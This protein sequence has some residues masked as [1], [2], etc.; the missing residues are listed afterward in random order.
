[1]IVIE[2]I[3]GQF[4]NKLLYYNN[5]VQVSNRYSVDYFIHEFVGDDIFKFSVDRSGIVPHHTT[6]ITSSDLLNSRVSISTC[7][8]TLLKP[9]LGELFF[10]FCDVDTHKI[11]EFKDVLVPTPSTGTSVGIHFRGK[12]FKSWNPLSI[13]PTKYYVDSMSYVLDTYND[14][15]FTLYTDDMS[16]VSY[17]EVIGYLESNNLTFMTGNINSLSEDFINLSYCDIIISSPSTFAICAGFC[18]K[19][20]KKIIHS[21]S[22]VDYRVLSNGRF[23][24]GFDCGGNSNYGKYKLI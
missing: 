1:M 23:W 13:L 8:I 21:K 9:C 5:L 22:W 19:R 6:T 20:N 7:D 2:D 12:D 15:V 4:G 14:I 17:I 24:V 10:D 11:F 18:G 16:L 3:I